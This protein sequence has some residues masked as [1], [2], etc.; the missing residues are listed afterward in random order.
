M[1][2]FIRRFAIALIM[3][4]FIGMLMIGGKVI[5]AEEKTDWHW[6]VDGIITSSFHDRNGEHNGIDIAAPMGTPVVAAKSGVVKRA[7]HSSSYGNVIFI[8]HKN[9]YESVYAH[10]KRR[11]VNQ[12]DHVKLGQV[13]GQVG[14]TGH[15]TG[16]HLH[17]EVH[18]GL[19]NVHK[20]NAV[21]PMLMVADS[22]NPAVQTGGSAESGNHRAEKE[23]S[24]VNQKRLK[25]QKALLNA[26]VQRDEKNRLSQQRTEKLTITVKKGDTLWALAHQFDLPISSLKEWNNLSS[27]MI[28]IGSELTIYTD[29][30][31]TYK[32]QSGDTIKSIARKTGTSVHSLIKYNHLKD[33][34]IHPSEILITGIQSV[35]E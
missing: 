4:I 16:P 29:R 33:T 12:G 20:T 19:W 26:A 30:L 23:N 14:S 3:M 17:F 5:H 11:L 24:K 13:I 22:E 31:E 35:G 9:G 6:P 2:D 15:S 34:M 27:N 18:N 32:V 1:V 7:Y 21:N 25:K 10:L 8:L 28:K